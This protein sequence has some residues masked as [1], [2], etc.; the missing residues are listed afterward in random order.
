MSTDKG[1]FVVQVRGDERWK[2]PLQDHLQEHA[3]RSVEPLFR[4][5]QTHQALEMNQVR[6]SAR[7][8]QCFCLLEDIERLFNSTFN[9]HFASIFFPDGRK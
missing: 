6:H 8:I 3:C 2:V 1:V 7:L 9:F 4:P 5:A